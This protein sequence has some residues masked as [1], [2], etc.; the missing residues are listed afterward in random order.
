[1][2]DLAYI[3]GRHSDPLR[4]RSTMNDVIGGMFGAIG[5]MSALARRAVTS[6][7]QE[8]QT[9]L[10]KMN[11][12]LVAQYT[13]QFAFP[14]QAALRLPSRL[15]ASGIC[16]V[17]TVRDGEQIFLAVVSDTQ[18]TQSCRAFALIDWQSDACLARNSDGVRASGSCLRCAS[19]WP[20][21]EQSHSA[22][23]LRR[24]V[25]PLRQS[26]S[27]KICLTVR[28]CWPKKALPTL[29]LQMAEAHGLPAAVDIQQAAA[30][31]S[32]ELTAAA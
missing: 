16:S 14:N 19:T 32:P 27:L 22:P 2:G 30:R 3:S 11:V 25:C 13:M 9:A 12:F 23:C 29:C 6:K 26:L 8:V 21:S 28:I 18:W 10:F 17:F 15:S 31:L 24:M 20:I 1:M 4:A 5:A 7:G